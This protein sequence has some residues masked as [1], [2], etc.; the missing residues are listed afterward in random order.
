MTKFI[1][2]LK[3][4]LLGYSQRQIVD[5]LSVSRNTITKSLNILLIKSHHSNQ[6]GVN[7][8]I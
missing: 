1:E 8:L 6:K 3:Y 2:I 4:R 7:S 5:I